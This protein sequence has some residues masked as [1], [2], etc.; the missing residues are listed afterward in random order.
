VGSILPLVVGVL[1]AGDLI[2]NGSR[3]V[4]Y[5]DYRP[6]YVNDDLIQWF[7][8][9][10]A[11]FRVKLW[12]EN[13]YLRSI[14]TDSLPYYGIDV[15]DAIMSR[16]PERYSETL[17]AAREGHLPL[18]KF[19]QIFNV[20]YVLSA[21]PVEGTDVLL[22]PLA[23]FKTVEGSDT[24]PTCYV[25]EVSDFMPRAYVVDKFEAAAPEKTLATLARPDFDLRRTVV[26]EKQ[27]DLINKNDK[28]KH[29]GGEVEWNIESFSQAP[30][31][32][33]MRVTVNRPALLVLED[34]F[35]ENWH[36]RVDSQEVEV[37]RANY[38][39]RAV[40]VPK[41]THSVVF[42]YRPAVWGFALTVAGWVLLAAILLLQGI[43]FL[44]KENA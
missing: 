3:F 27:P 28:S 10:K 8:E 7:R 44:L 38:L 30:Q 13:A 25:Y 9:R 20:R 12:S 18:G 41:G 16:R 43:Q 4:S 14:V 39:M 35:D 40:V 26:L 29:D 34:F 37:L 2:A 1:L 5:Y 42:T 17:R 21:K 19:F 36:G 24:R 15:V 31:R 33:S 23:F 11:P 22:N 6:R 32:V